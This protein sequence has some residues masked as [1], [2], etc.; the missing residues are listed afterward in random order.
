MVRGGDAAPGQT[1]MGETRR[2]DYSAS[3]GAV[4]VLRAGPPATLNG[5]PGGLGHDEQGEGSTLIMTI[6]ITNETRRRSMTEG[7]KRA[8]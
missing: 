8:A 7:M 1:G 3:S 5:G 2:P 4:L 6:V